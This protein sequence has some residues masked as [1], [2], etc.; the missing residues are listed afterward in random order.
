MK[1]APPSPP[2]PQLMFSLEIKV[3]QKYKDV[4]L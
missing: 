3:L 2:P 1:L 4:P